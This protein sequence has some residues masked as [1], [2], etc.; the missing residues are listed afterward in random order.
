MDTHY[1]QE[2]TEG[3]TSCRNNEDWNASI[4]ADHHDTNGEAQPVDLIAWWRLA[5][6]SRNVVNY[7]SSDYIV[8]Q[9]IIHYI[10][11]TYF[12]FLSPL[13]QPHLFGF[14]RN[15]HSFQAEHCQFVFLSR[16]SITTN[17]LDT[18]MVKRCAKF[19]STL[20][21]WYI[22]AKEALVMSLGQQTKIVEFPRENA[23]GLGTIKKAE[24]YIRKC[25]C[26][27]LTHQNQMF[28]CKTAIVT[29]L[30]ICNI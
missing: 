29:W 24:V 6:S 18:S 17:G 30:D 15:H 12:V 4:T 10:I 21:L 13:K 28:I 23:V 1:Q 2:N 8:R 22:I 7:I 5:V 11:M 26:Y 16:P 3:I 27:C 19:A 20:T 25:V 9:T 14:R